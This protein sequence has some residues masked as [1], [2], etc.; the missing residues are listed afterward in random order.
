MLLQINH[1]RSSGGKYFTVKKIAF[2]PLPALDHDRL[3][4][5]RTSEK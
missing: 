2:M 5:L 4:Y 3:V 1:Q